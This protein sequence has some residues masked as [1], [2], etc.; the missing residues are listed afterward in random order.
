MKTRLLIIIVVLITGIILAGLIFSFLLSDNENTSSGSMFP[1]PS[2][3]HV[4]I[5]SLEN[6]FDYDSLSFKEKSR[7][8]QFAKT[9][10][11]NETD[12][13]QFQ[14]LLSAI[15]DIGK[16]DS[17]PNKGYSDI[18]EEERRSFKKFIM[19]ISE[20]QTGIASSSYY[21]LEFQENVYHIDYNFRQHPANDLFL[22]VFVMDPK[23]TTSLFVEIK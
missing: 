18:S 20:E 3:K 15:G 6:D 16:Y 23:D 2:L 5:T 19:S 1:T 8:S 17:F 13:K 21:S 7:N 9:L 12:L 14:S 11:V 10:L 22:Y 4:I